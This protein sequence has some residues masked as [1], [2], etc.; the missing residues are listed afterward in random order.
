MIVVLVLKISTSMMDYQE[1]KIGEVP[2]IDLDYY[3]QNKNK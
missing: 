3:K 1:F 2:L